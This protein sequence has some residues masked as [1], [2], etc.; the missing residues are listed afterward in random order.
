[1]GSTNV[2]LGI[3]EGAAVAACVKAVVPSGR[4]VA[5]RDT[6]ILMGVAAGSTSMSTRIKLGTQRHR[7][8]EQ[9]LHGL[10]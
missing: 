10:M 8:M 9:R 6:L 4:A 5:V 2:G 7:G 3:A 1:M